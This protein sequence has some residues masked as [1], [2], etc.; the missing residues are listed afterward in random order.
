MAQNDTFA[1]TTGIRHRRVL[2]NAMIPDDGILRLHVPVDVRLA[3]AVLTVTVQ[4]DEPLPAAE[5]SA[6]YRDALDQVIGSIDDPTF[7][8]PPQPTL[9][10]RQFSE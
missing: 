5:T 7:E 8:R 1:E 10:E 3:G 4:F 6:D 2:I 9:V